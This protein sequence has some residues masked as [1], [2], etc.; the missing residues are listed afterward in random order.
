MKDKA[1]TKKKSQSLNDKVWEH[2]K[3]KHQN[4]LIIHKRQSLTN[5]R[6]QR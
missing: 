6:Q 3:T 1:V 5:K 2:D 4:T